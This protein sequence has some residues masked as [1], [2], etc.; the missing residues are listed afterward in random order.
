MTY[1]EFVALDARDIGALSPELTILA[2]DRAGRWE[3][4]H[5]R[6]AESETPDT[7]RLHAYLHRKEGDL[8]NARYWYDRS[9]EPV[10]AASLDE[11]W[12]TL[13]RR[14]LMRYKPG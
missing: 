7:K 8:A 1:E 12:S 13:A 10:P 5:A 2:L 14:Y 11:E 3:A 4:A 6:A 9:G